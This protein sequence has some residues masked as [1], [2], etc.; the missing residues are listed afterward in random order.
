MLSSFVVSPLL[1]P[2]LDDMYENVFWSEC[3]SQYDFKSDY[4]VSREF[5]RVSERNQTYPV[6]D[7]ENSHSSSRKYIR[8]WSTNSRLLKK[9]KYCIFCSPLW[10]FDKVGKN[11]RCHLVL[12]VKIELFFFE[13]NLTFHSLHW[14]TS[15]YFP[16][17][18]Q[19]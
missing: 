3:A 13:D 18:F 17:F 7:G 8:W 15:C 16:S 10:S 5:N 19:I 2:H 4:R 1:T 12:E 9:Q 14:T 11:I 6:Q